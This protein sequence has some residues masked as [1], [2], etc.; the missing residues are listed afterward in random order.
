VRRVFVQSFGCR[1]SQADGASI[2]ALL[3]DSGWLPV[4]DASQ[5][6]LVILNTCT[7]THAADVD[8]RRIVRNTHRDYPNAEVLVTGCYAQRAPQE[9]AQIDGVRWVVGNSH[10]TQIAEIVAPSSEL[11]HG[12]IQIADINALTHFAASPVRDIREDRTRPNLKIQDGC[13]NR[14][15]FCIIPAVR[16]RSRSASLDAVLSQIEDLASR[17]V[18]VVLSGINLGRWG[19]DLPGGL[20]F[21]DLLRSILRETE[22]Q[23]LRI[24]SV[25]P[26][27]WSADLLQLFADEPRIA[28]HIHMPLQSGS[29]A[30]LKRMFR[31]YRTRHYE[32][33]LQLA[34]Q[35][36]PDAAIGADVM[37]GFPGETDDEFEETCRF[38][39]NQ[40]FTY[41]H[42]FT[43]SERPG[44]AAASHPGVV[45]TKLRHERTN[46]LRELSNR[47]NLEFR[48][49]MLGK[50]LP[51]VTLEQPG[52]ALTSNFLKVELSH[53]RQ[54]N[55]AVDVNI[56]RVTATGLR[57]L[58]LLPCFS[59]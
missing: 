3:E 55:Q 41:L 42:V 23:R 53:P 16:G 15:S 29:D 25:E 50:T 43:Y 12:Q 56:G 48:R 24:S 11:Y 58:E 44:T 39:E 17:Y 22:I 37:T 46:R 30:V 40:P 47:K 9:L 54:S 19:R 45:S 7:V 51:A 10:K 8:A 28:R 21:V 18:E 38:I 49:R 14:C 33:R 13:G 27:D 6:D 26:M 35:L 34:H 2:E 36:M 32:S 20:R 5:A 4:R 59:I 52:M 31:K 1:A 57:E